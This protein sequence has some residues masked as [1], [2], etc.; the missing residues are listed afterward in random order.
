LSQPQLYEVNF[1]FEP[2]IEDDFT[3]LQGPNLSLDITQQTGTS[4]EQFSINTLINS[5]VTSS[6]NQIKS[7]L[8]EKEINTMRTIV[9]LLTL[10]Q[11]KLD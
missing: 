5:N 10:V 9:I 11:L 3:Y 7:L 1:P 8:S 4:G 6:V 2:I